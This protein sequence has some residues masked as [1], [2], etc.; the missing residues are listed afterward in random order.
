IAAIF[1][2]KIT[3]WNDPKIAAENPD[4]NLPDAPITAVHRSDESGTTENLTNYLATVAED[5]WPHGEVGEWP[6]EAGEG[7]NGTSGVVTA[8]KDGTNTIGYADASQAGELGTVNVKVGAEYVGPTPEAAAK[9]LEVSPRVEG[10]P[11]VDMA[12]D[13][14]YKTAEAGVYPIVLTSYLLA[15]QTYDDQ[16]TA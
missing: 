8:V 1:D 2:D 15:C 10:R 13:L 16:E 11:E 12:V 14:D 7:A 9:I 3:K 6:I 5:A 4:A